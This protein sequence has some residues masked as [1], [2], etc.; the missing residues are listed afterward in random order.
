MKALITS[1]AT[2]ST[3]H[4]VLILS[5]VGAAGAVLG[6]IRVLGVSLGI[7]GVLFASLLFG[8]FGLVI[9]APV[10][11]FMRDFGFVLFA[12]TLGLQIGPGFVG[13]P[14]QRGLWLNI[15]AAA[16][17]TTDVAFAT[18]WIL[19]AKIPRPTGLGVLSGATTSTPSFA[20]ARQAFKQPG[21][22]EDPMIRQSLGYA[23]AYATVSPFTL[24]LRVLSAQ[25]LVFFRF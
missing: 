24:L 13:A 16:I 5:P 8:H 25:L 2:A 22:A 11:E 7:V 10:L 12:S 14:R 15:F 9:D 23:I 21:A 19:G 4:Q 1:W 3:M 20:A 18:T 17:V 6:K